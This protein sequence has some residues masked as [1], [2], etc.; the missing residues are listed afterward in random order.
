MDH[1]GRSPVAQGLG[2]VQCRRI[3][4]GAQFY[5]S[6]PVPAWAFRYTSSYFRVFRKRPF[7]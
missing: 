6:S 7:M 4:V 3:E 1:G 5:L 2:A